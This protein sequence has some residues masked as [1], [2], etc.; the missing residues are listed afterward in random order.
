METSSAGIASSTARRRP[1]SKSATGC[2]ST[3]GARG[4]RPKARGRSSLTDSGNLVCCGSSASRIPATRLRSM[5][6]KNPGCETQA[7]DATTTGVCGYS[8]PN[9]RRSTDARELQGG[10][11]AF[12]GA[13][14]TA[15]PGAAS[16]GCSASSAVVAGDD[17]TANPL[18]SH[19]GK[20]PRNQYTV[21]N[22]LDNATFAALY[23]FQHS[24]PL[25]WKITGLVLS[26]FSGPAQSSSAGSNATSFKLFSPYGIDTAPRICFSWYSLTSRTSMMGTP[27]C[28][29]AT[30]SVAVTIFAP[31]SCDGV[32]LPS[33]ATY[34]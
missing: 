12:A 1:T 32:Q 34:L 16:G 15:G 10:Y 2:C 6:C 27:F 14:A 19:S 23:D 22:P 8:S 9:R 29:K 28:C 11:G 24:A 17:S 31:G 25:Q 33:A 7:G 5:C 21:V 30:T 13:C 3:P 26:S 18:L 20:P 4:S